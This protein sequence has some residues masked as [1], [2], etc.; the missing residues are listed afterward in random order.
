MSPCIQFQNHV[1]GYL[2][3]AE[4]SHNNH[5]PK[6]EDQ[7]NLTSL[8]VGGPTLSLSVMA[9][10]DR[11]IMKQSLDWAA[12]VPDVVIAGGKIVRFMNDIAAF[13]V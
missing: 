2:Q 12:G 11:K 4:W 1:S 7:V 13:K 9:G 5:W 3:E 10:V 6:F 8:T